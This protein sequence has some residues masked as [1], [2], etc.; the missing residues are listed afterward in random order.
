[1]TCTWVDCQEPSEHEHP[2]EF[3]WVNP[4]DPTA[5]EVHVRVKD[6]GTVTLSEPVMAQLLTDAGWERAR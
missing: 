4:G 6:D 5:G 1:M 2:S 3:V